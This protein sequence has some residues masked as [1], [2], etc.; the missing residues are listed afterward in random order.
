MIGTTAT[1][2]SVA[3]LLIAMMPVTAGGTAEGRD[4]IV[5]GVIPAV[6]APMIDGSGRGFG[7]EP[8]E[9]LG[10]VK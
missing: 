9:G 4:A 8:T 3:G 5:I 7:T 2:E 1:T 6:I 10:S